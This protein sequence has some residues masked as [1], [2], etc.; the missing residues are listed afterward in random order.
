MKYLLLIHLD[1]ATQPGPE[2]LK[3]STSRSRDDLKA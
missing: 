3:P 1:E 2:D